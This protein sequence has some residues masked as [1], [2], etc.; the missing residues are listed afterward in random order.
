MRKPCNRG[1]R[2]A[3]VGAAP[4]SPL[5]RVPVDED[6]SPPLLA[7]TL[8]CRRPRE[9][10]SLLRVHSSPSPSPSSESGWRAL[11][12]SS[13]ASAACE[14][15]L[16]HLLELSPC[17]SVQAALLPSFREEAAS[18]SILTFFALVPDA[19]DFRLP[20]HADAWVSSP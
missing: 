12:A 4:S 1:S 14:F 3:A 2:V 20:L 19:L 6:A 7:P 5:V 9:A 17:V 10:E 11:R 8:L 13:Q 16:D 15:F 18:S